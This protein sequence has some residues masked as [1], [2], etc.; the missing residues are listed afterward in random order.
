HHLAGQHQVHAGDVPCLAGGDRLD[1]GVRERAAQD[2][3]VQHAR[4]HDV[5]GVVALA[6][7]EPAV[8]DALSAC[9]QTAPPA[10]VY[11][12]RPVLSAP[13][14]ASLRPTAWTSR[15]SG[16][17][18]SGTGCPTGPS[19]LLLRSDPD[20]PPAAPWPPSSFRACRTRTAGRAPHGSPPAAGA[21]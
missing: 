4:Q 21:A 3:H 10:P 9:A 16:H 17:P 18:C 20:W 1:P 12:L 2:L 6:A 13:I 7:D 14:A 15:C 19:A 11:R 5:V 8:L